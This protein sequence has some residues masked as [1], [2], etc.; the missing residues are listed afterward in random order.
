M[1]TF[2][3]YGI[4][5]NTYSNEKRFRLTSVAKIETK[6]FMFNSTFYENRAVYEIMSKNMVQSERPQTTKNMAHA[7]CM[8]GKVRLHGHTHRDRNT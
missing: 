7:L 3:I 2:H 4:S 5:L 1:K 6:H 8:L